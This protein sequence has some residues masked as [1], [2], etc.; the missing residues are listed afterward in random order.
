MLFTWQGIQFFVGGMLLVR[1][2]SLQILVQ[3][4][5]SSLVETLSAT[6]YV[7]SSSGH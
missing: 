5:V 1:F 6:V 3:P 2:E 7:G 4:V